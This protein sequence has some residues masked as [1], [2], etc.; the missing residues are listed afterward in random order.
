MKRILAFTMALAI[1]VGSMTFTFATA[2]KYGDVDG[3]DDVGISDV[4][5]IQ[6]HI[7]KIRTL[8]ETKL[9][10]A[11]VDDDGEISVL[12]GSTVQ[13]Y[14]AKIIEIF[15]AEENARP[16][17]PSYGSSL[18]P[19]T[20]PPTNNTPTQAQTQPPTQAPTLAPTQPPTQE[21]DDGTPGWFELE[22]LRLINIEREKRGL[23][24]VEFGYFYYD[25]AKVRA[26]E[27]DCVFSHVR[28][29]DRTWNTV[30]DDFGVMD[31]C[32]HYVAAENIAWGYRTPEAVVEGWMNSE[33]HRFNILYPDFTHLA[34]AK[35]ECSEQPGTYAIVQL[36]WAEL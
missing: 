16:I 25:C 27:I 5:A 17:N 19:A 28:P 22:V 1:I 9:E 31:D 35:H 21:V 26:E 14:L 7:A 36:F 11:D 30:F 24:T 6:L 12:D 15:P 23:G 20:K 34:V 10:F 13:R 3:D 2:L 29:D 33:G 4:S 18:E 8:D 32:Y